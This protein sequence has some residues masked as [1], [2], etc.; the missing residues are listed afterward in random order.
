VGRA[1]KSS[2]AY[3]ALAELAEL[4][5]GSALLDGKP[6]S[7]LDAA[8]LARGFTTD[9]DESFR[10]AIVAARLLV[11]AQ[12]FDAARS[13]ADSIL[14]VAAKESRKSLALPGL[15]VLIGRPTEAA[16]LLQQSE[17]DVRVAGG[18]GYVDLPLPVFQTQLALRAYAAAGAPAESIKVLSERL[19]AGI[20]AYFTQDSIAG[21][22]RAGSFGQVLRLGFPEQ[23]ERLLSLKAT[24]QVVRA[25]QLALT[26][27]G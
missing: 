27:R 10:L 26:N 4:S 18:H 16:R 9:P 5:G 25:E 1:P 6:I 24:D 8:R 22:A 21:E 13:V 19:D 17:T 2:A 11:K 7:A 3:A 20:G 23:P 14:V 15:A 12:Q